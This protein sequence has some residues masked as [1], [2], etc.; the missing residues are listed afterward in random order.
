M[1]R[2]NRA[3]GRDK[4]AKLLLRRERN[5]DRIAEA[6]VGGVFRLNPPPPK[7]T[8]VLKKPIAAPE[9]RGPDYLIQAFAVKFLHLFVHF[10][11]N[12]SASNAWQRLAT[13]L[14]L[15]HVPGMRVSQSSARSGRTKK[16]TF[17]RQRQLVRD[18]QSMRAESKKPISEV[19]AIRMLTS[20]APWK[21]YTPQSLRTRHVEAKKMDSHLRAVELALKAGIGERPM[22]TLYSARNQS[23]A[24]SVQAATRKTD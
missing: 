12:P 11:I 1:T 19:E 17:D 13:Q 5:R 23:G 14:A 9:F 18:V 24:V 3:A 20:K 4:I 10:G 15:H 21:S 7:Y 2:N 22:G 6:I 8:E 16:W